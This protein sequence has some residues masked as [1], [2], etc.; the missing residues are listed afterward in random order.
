MDHLHCSE[1]FESKNIYEQLTGI[2]SQEFGTHPFTQIIDRVQ[3]E[4]LLP[5]YF[6]MSLA[7]R[8]LQAAAQKDVIFD[9]IYENRNVPEEIEL[10]NAVANFLVW[11]ES[12]GNKLVLS[13]GKAGLPRI[14]DTHLWFHSNILRADVTKILGRP[15]SPHFSSAT[16]RYLITLYQGLA[17]TDTNQ[18]CHTWLL[19]NSTLPS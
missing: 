5:D 17:S 13:C 11:D 4:S 16:R 6:A 14:L 1:L 18:R 9:A 2:A 7:F 10:M 8:Y 3:L 12:G 19:L 15:V